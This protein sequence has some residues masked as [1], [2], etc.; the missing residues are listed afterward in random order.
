MLTI[1]KEN[2]SKAVAVFS[3]FHIPAVVI[4]RG[5]GMVFF[6]AAAQE[7]FQI[8]ESFSLEDFKQVSA[9]PDTLKDFIIQ[10]GTSD[11]VSPHGM[12]WIS[13]ALQGIDKSYPVVYSAWQDDPDIVAVQGTI[14]QRL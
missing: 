1:S 13:L 7:L 6:N 9:A 2:T 3:R 14:R 11:V 4:D 12:E 10:I 5:D 8:D